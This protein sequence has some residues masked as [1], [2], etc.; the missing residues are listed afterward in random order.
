VYRRLGGE[1][2][3][4]EKQVIVIFAMKNEMKIIHWE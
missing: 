4:R 1:K 3:E 2:G